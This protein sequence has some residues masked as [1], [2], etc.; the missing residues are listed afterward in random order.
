MTAYAIGNALLWVAISAAW[1]WAFW[2]LLRVVDHYRR[3]YHK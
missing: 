1:G 2:N 3:R